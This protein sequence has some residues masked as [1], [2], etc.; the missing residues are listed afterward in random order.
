MDTFHHGLEGVEVADLWHLDFGGEIFEQVFIDDAI[1]SGKESKYHGD[2]MFLAFSECFEMLL[3]V[4]QVN[5]FGHPEARGLVLGHFPR[6]LVFDGKQDKAVAAGGKDRF[7]INRHHDA[8]GEMRLN[9]SGVAGL[10]HAA[11]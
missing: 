7:R 5:F 9:G 3:V 8:F 4:L 11:R 10:I 2:E 6:C 1:G